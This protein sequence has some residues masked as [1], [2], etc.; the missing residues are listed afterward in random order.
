[1]ATTK[2]N[3][4][5][6]AVN[7]ISG[8][9][10]ADGA[11]TSTHLAANCVDTAELVTGS[12]DTIH[13]AANQVTSAK[14]VS[15]AVLTRH[16]ADDQV[17]QAL[18]AVNSVGIS[19][20]AVTD[21]SSGQVLQTNGSGTL[22]FATVS[23]T[24]INNNANNRVIT[25]SGTANTLEGE[26]N[27]TF[28]GSKAQITTTA[29]GDETVLRIFQDSN[30]PSQEARITFARDCDAGTDRDVAHIAAVR[31]GGNDTALHF[32]TDTSGTGSSATV[33]QTISADGNTIMSAS[34]ASDGCSLFVETANSAD[35]GIAFGRN[36][37]NNLKTG[38]RSASAG[39]SSAMFMKLAIGENTGEI[40]NSSPQF[41]FYYNGNLT[42]TGSVSSDRRLKENIV[43]I[44]DGSTALI[45]SLNPVSFN[46]I[47][48]PVHKAGFIAQEVETVKSSLVNGGEED[49]EGNETIRGVD[50]YGIL[51]HAVKAIQELEARV[52]ILEG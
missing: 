26:A 17:T 28:D 11:I 13:I 15:D 41:T 50:Y 51:A 7:A 42:A 4:E 21:G 48:S 5:F 30:T 44:P 27:L 33:K 19:E 18:I 23:G 10:I 45:K 43:D 22:S 20:L 35:T 8:T 40:T 3:T 38:M 32:F 37:T 2:V 12:I 24:T 16:I 39:T 6:I 36:G 34:R 46:L 31:E 9:I 52:K 1:M 14:I 29:T 49:E 25:G 47:G